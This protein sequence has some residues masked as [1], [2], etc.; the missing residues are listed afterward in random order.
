[1]E[2]DIEL[3]GVIKRYGRTT[4][5]SGVSFKVTHGAIHGFLGP[6]GAG[7]STTMKIIAGIMSADEGSV[8]LLNATM[9][10][11]HDKSVVG[12]L[13]ETPPV[14]PNMSVENFL[15]FVAAIND[16]SS[17]DRAPQVEKAIASC[18]LGG[19]RK[20]LVGN[21]SKGYQ[22]RVGI[23]QMLT[24]NPKVIILDEPTVGLD[25]ESVVQIRNLIRD[26]SQKEGRTVI[27][28]SHLLHEVK[29]LC[30]ELTII[31]EGKIIESGPVQDIV[32][33]YHVQV[34]VKAL[35]KEFNSNI[36]NQLK[37]IGIN[38]IECVALSDG[39]QL[40]LFLS[41]EMKLESISELLVREGAGL[42]S[43]SKEELS[44]EEIFSM[45]I[46]KGRVQ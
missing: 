16:V 22:Q 28:S 12:L 33:N 8:R 19:V 18:G 7:K 17:K 25:P 5:L 37:K 14:Y 41:G 3:D 32:K 24:H 36:E 1:V 27:F 42:L 2:F 23:A 29:E 26:L 31:N 9:Q 46:S 20:R 6:N 10:T 43:F 35:V 21:L 15:N 38:K 4:A 11:L 40:R 30:S 44:L 39:T 34:V 13:P 45:A